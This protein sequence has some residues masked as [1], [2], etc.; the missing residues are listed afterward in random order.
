MMDLPPKLARIKPGDPV[1]LVNLF[2]RRL[3]TVT[4]VSRRGFTV[5][6]AKFLFDGRGR[7]HCKYV[8]LLPDPEELQVRQPLRERAAI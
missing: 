4:K 1:A 6:R 8:A 5:G 3:A 7:G 2:G